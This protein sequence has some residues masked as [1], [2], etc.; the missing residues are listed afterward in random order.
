VLNLLF[1]A[2]STG[3]AYDDNLNNMN[4]QHNSPFLNKIP[5]Y[6]SLVESESDNDKSSRIHYLRESNEKKKGKYNY[7]DFRNYR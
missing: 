2:G 5:S 3:E 4:N 7:K 1:I 6:P